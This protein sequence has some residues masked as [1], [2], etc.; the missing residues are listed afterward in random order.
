MFISGLSTKPTTDEKLSVME[1]RNQLQSKISHYE[2]NW[3][4]LIGND[5][6]DL[7]AEEEEWA[8]SASPGGENEWEDCEGSEQPELIKL[9][10]PSQMKEDVLA[11]AGLE[12][13]KSQE[14]ELRVGQMNDALQGLRIALGEKSL[15][16]RTSV[17]N[18]KTQR[19]VGRAWAQV[20][21]E[22][23]KVQK[24]L[25]AYNRAREAF[26]RLS[27]ADSR[28]NKFKTIT[29]DDLK[30]SGDIVEENRIGQRSDALSWIWRIEGDVEEMVG[31]DYPRMKECE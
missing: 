15:L 14:A 2:S 23:E 5:L 21:R 7:V 9:L 29:K 4:G 10:L 25:R 31:E 27:P 1:R 28:F 11:K 13:L 17:R 6:E 12:R 3:T 24:Q 8:S 26:I 20:R 19:T 30:V 16:L 18:N 22:E